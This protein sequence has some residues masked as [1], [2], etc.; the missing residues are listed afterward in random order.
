M[1][2][3]GCRSMIAPLKV[4]LLK[5][6]K[7]AFVSQD[8]LQIE[9]ERHGYTCCPDY[10]KALQEFEYFKS[11]LERFVEMIVYLPYDES[12]SLD[13]IYTHDP[14]QITENGAIFMN[15]GKE[16]RRN[17]PKAVRD[18]L[19]ALGIP[20][21]GTITDPG[22][23]EGGDVL[24]LDEHGVA[25]GIG[26]RTNSEGVRQFLSLLSPITKQHFVFDMPHYKG[27]KEC[28]HLMSVVSLID[29]DLAVAYSP[30]MPVRLRQFL[31]EQGYS[32][33][34]VPK[35]EYE[36]LGCN[37]LTLAPRICVVLEGNNYVSSELRRHGAEVYEYP[38]E[39]ISLLG[40]GGPTCLTRP[41]LRSW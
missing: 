13:S 30:L 1:N 16:L 37:V 12:T 41:L 21:L 27:P 35:E 18:Y 2:S 14:V 31:I 9:W 26:Y 22:K 19:K 20:E 25:L 4:V 38:G 36:T 6:P 8:N 34:E 23:M 28:L 29:K 33:I 39:N 5:H 10:K 40:T 3:Y 24:W 7:D 11:I 15:M 32:L 17:E